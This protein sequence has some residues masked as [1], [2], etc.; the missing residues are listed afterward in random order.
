VLSDLPNTL[1]E[2]IRE[3]TSTIFGSIYSSIDTISAGL[4]IVC[5]DLK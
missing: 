3:E 5:K 4:Y 1:A 2:P